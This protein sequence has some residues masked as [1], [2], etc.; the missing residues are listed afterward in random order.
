MLLLVCLLNY[1]QEILRILTF[2]GLE[3]LHVS[4]ISK[5]VFNALNSFF[6]PLNPEDVHAYVS[7]YLLRQSKNPS[8][9]VERIERGVYRLNPSSVET[10]QLMLQFRHEEEQIEE[11]P[12][13]HDESLSLF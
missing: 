3:G 2:A 13:S 7:S 11:F 6:L 5:H 8:S 9:V 12:T 1:D 4:K 10:N